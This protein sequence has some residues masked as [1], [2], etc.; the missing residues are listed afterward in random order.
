MA[1]ISEAQ[2]NAK[3]DDEKYALFSTAI[4]AV[5]VKQEKL[6]ATRAGWQ[7]TEQQLAD[8]R[9]QLQTT[10]EKLESATQTI[11][12][13]QSEIDSVNEQLIAEKDDN[14]RNV[15]R[16]NQ[17]IDFLLQADRSRQALAKD[18][19]GNDTAI[20]VFS[21]GSREAV[22][23]DEQGIS[24]GVGEQVG[25]NTSFHSAVGFPQIRCLGGKTNLQSV[26]QSFPLHSA[27]T[28]QQCTPHNATVERSALA[29]PLSQPFL[30]PN[31]PDQVAPPAPRSLS[32]IREHK[33]FPRDYDDDR[34]GFKRFK[35]S[36]KLAVRECQASDADAILVLELVL[37]GS[38]VDAFFC[39]LEVT[40]LQNKTLD[41]V[42]DELEENLFP[43]PSW[44]QTM[45]SYQDYQQEPEQSVVAYH[46]EL[47]KRFMPYA[48]H[49][50]LPPEAWDIELLAH[51]RC[52]DKGLRPE[53]QYKL[54]TMMCV[55]PVLSTDLKQFLGV[56]TNVEKMLKDQEPNAGVPFEHAT[57]SFPAESPAIVKEDWFC[58]Q[59]KR[60]ISSCQVKSPCRSIC[61]FPAH[62]ASGLK[63]CAGQCRD[64]YRQSKQQSGVSL[65]E[66]E[67][68][69]TSRE[70]FPP[71]PTM[72]TVHAIVACTFPPLPP[73]QVDSE[74]TCS[75]WVASQA[76]PQKQVEQASQAMVGTLEGWTSSTPSPLLGQVRP[77]K[78]VKSLEQKA[79]RYRSGQ[80]G[81]ADDWWAA[82]RYWWPGR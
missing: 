46:S 39:R 66:E 6:E 18:S 52:R 65:V 69:P 50:Q 40:G 57:T 35:G 61:T 54:E 71:F 38:Q 34:I 58:L 29:P 11:E 26:S 25:G 76:S 41:Q 75:E 80:Q 72:H 79:K 1:A 42:L 74:V 27:G 67:P 9:V 43:T 10:T 31:Q 68:D 51:M 15:T 23:S 8:T 82:R 70:T 44:M 28:Q 30:V 63:H 56:A 37:S 60:P 78:L 7:S 16:S 55:N 14:R 47:L 4:T 45:S 48:R 49:Q 24:T 36:Y 32:A 19:D 81:Q 17:M 21:G 77:S 33:V 53:I 20:G 62:M 5:S 22:V 59:H 3:T 64:N 12:E 73:R 2:W 13:A